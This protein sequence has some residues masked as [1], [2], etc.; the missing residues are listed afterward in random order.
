MDWRRTENPQGAFPEHY[1]R[2]EI[3]VSN[4]SPENFENILSSLKKKKFYSLSFANLGD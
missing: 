2:T 4:I 1:G 3:L